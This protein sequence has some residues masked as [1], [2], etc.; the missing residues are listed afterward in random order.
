MR[1]LILF[2]KNFYEVFVGDFAVV[3]KIVP[4]KGFCLFHCFIKRIRLNI[5]TSVFNIC[6]CNAIFSD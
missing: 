6:N 2:I 4:I 1:I 3:D 5:N